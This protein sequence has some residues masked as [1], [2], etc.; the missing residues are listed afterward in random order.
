M[1][2]CLHR[3]ACSTQSEEESNVNVL[4]VDGRLGLR[5]CRD[6]QPGTELLLLEDQQEVS[7]EEELLQVKACEN[8][9]RPNRDQDEALEAITLDHRSGCSCKFIPDICAV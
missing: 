2:N 6:I 9:S 1:F 8:S 4:E 3:F 5:V 7:F